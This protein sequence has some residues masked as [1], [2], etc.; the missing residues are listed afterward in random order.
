[1]S[2]NFPNKLNDL[3][4]SFGLSDEQV[5][6]VVVLVTAKLRDVEDACDETAEVGRL[7]AAL[8]SVVARH[9]SEDAGAG[10]TRGGGMAWAM[11]DDARVALGLD[12]MPKKGK[13]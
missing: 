6:Q 9:D 12:R 1:M 11:A 10:F 5:R 4:M 13:R 8:E 7:R 2:V 3:L